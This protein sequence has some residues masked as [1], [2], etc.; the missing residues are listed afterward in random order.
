MNLDARARASA[1]ALHRS[2]TRVDP[3]AGLDNL[4]RRRRRRL[5]GKAVTALATAAALALVAWVGVRG[6]HEDAI[7]APPSPPSFGRVT[8]TIPV[9][10]GPADVLVSDGAVWVANA[11]QGTVS[12]ID[13]A[14]NTVTR[15]I[16]VGRN[17]SRLA[18]G[19]GSI[20][21][22]NN[23]GTVS[24]INART[25]RVTATIPVTGI[26]PSDL[27]AGAGAV[28]VTSGA[29]ARLMRV[30]PASNQQV[31]VP[32]GLDA[33]PNGIAVVD[34]LVW[35]SYSGQPSHVTRIDPS[36]NQIADT[37]TTPGDGQLAV[38]GASM[39]QTGIATQAVYRLDPRSGRLRARIPI[40]VVP[41]R[42]TVGAE[43]LWV[44]S[45]SGKVTRIDLAT[46]K[47][48]GTFQVAGPAPAVAAGAGSVWIVDTAHAALLR[49]QP[50]G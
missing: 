21:A 20:W 46:D 34:G 13:P 43:S 40:G 33:A 47:I 27:A 36:T 41:D 6:P 14:T 4:L 28:W 45:A 8:A 30:D 50:T 22:A 1:E 17:P 10:A 35:L 37:V 2:A 11:T 31:A 49:V 44:G 18:A 3:V 26:R 9:G 25:G 29:G 38:G 42:L 5:V 15:T 7:V 24:R 39:W 23:D 12:R 16:R 19:Y 32:E 48:T